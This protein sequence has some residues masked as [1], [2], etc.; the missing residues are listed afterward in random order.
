MDTTSTID[1]ATSLTGVGPRNWQAFTAETPGGIPF[2]G[3][4][5][6]AENAWMGA[7]AIDQVEGESTFQLERGMPHLVYPYPPP[8]RDRKS[9]V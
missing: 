9:V 7:V 5:C 8:P 6:V 2:A 1:L 3:L 4:I